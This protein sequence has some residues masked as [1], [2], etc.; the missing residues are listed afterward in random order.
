MMTEMLLNISLELEKSRNALGWSYA[1]VSRE[2]C[3]S[4]YRLEQVFSGS[5]RMRLVDVMKVARAMR[6]E[7]RFVQ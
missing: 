7:V 1:K 4:M 5:E 3:V 2:S 6:L